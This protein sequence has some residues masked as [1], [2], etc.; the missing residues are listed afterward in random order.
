MPGTEPKDHDFAD[1]QKVI[2]EWASPS[3]I[4]KITVWISY[5]DFQIILKELRSPQDVIEAVKVLKAQ[6]ESRER[7]DWFRRIFRDFGKWLLIIFGGFATI[8]AGLAVL[9]QVW[10]I[11]LA[12]LGAGP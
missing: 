10:R 11:A 9:P 4:R 6:A 12:V 3:E 2:S 5:A 7:W 8:Q 1:Y